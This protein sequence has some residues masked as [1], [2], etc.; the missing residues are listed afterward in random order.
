MIGLRRRITQGVPD[1]IDNNL[2]EL[3]GVRDKDA[4]SFRKSP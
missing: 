4:E 3:V 1:Q 2:F